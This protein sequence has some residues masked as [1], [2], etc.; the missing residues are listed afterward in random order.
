MVNNLFIYTNGELHVLFKKDIINVIR[1]G[2]YE[3]TML[4]SY[5]IKYTCQL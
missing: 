2:V 5:T 1:T 4:R 3:N